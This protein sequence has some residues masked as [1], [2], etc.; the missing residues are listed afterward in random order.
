MLLTATHCSTLQHT[1][2]HCSTLQHTVAHCNTLQ[3]TLDADDCNA[4]QHAATQIGFGYCQEVGR[5]CTCTRGW[6][7]RCSYKM[8]VYTRMYIHVCIYTY[9]Y[10][11][12]YIHIRIYINV[13]I[14]TYKYQIRV[15]TG[16]M[17]SFDDQRM[18]GSLFLFHTRARARNLSVGWETQIETP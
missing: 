17:S 13:Y 9:V 8:Y 4:L 16:E 1:A 6:G 2:A 11:R 15:L 3:H 12:L 10:T 7:G 14:S 5:G 18:Q